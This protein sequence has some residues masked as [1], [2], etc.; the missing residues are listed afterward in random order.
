MDGGRGKSWSGET[1]ASSSRSEQERPPERACE[2]SSQRTDFPE[3]KML[4]GDR[5]PK[6]RTTSQFGWRGLYAERRQLLVG[7]NE[8]SA[9]PDCGIWCEC[10]LLRGIP[11]FEKPRRKE[12]VVRLNG[13]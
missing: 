13:P 1:A 3:P 6:W 2:V 11:P 9:I 8:M 5:R 12:M 4:F 10:L 7:R